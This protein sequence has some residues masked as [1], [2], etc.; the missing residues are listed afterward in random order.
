MDRPFG[1][2]DGQGLDQFRK[3]GGFVGS[4][5][6]ITVEHV[7]VSGGQTRA[8]ASLRVCAVMDAEGQAKLPGQI[9][10]QFE[11][12]G[13]S[14]IRQTMPIQMCRSQA[15]SQHCPDLCPELDLDLFQFGPGEQLRN[16]VVGEE[17]AGFVNQ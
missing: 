10:G 9:Q 15:R 14:A 11:N 12:I 5:K 17:E 6:V 13:A 2:T 16:V 8:P 4:D 1:E 7:V 3:S